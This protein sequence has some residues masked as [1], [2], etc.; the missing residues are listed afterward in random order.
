MSRA[1]NFDY[2]VNSG[3][4]G[5]VMGP[6]L[7]T[8]W[9]LLALSVIPAWVTHVV[10]CITNEQWGFLIAGALAAPIAVIHGWGIWLGAW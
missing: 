9:I 7:L 6:T 10:R 8:L 4:F 3:F 2:Q 1:I 5:R